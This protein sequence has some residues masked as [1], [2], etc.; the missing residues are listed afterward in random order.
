MHRQ[1]SSILPTFLIDPSSRANHFN[2]SLVSS[3]TLLLPQ[4][5]L[6]DANCNCLAGYWRNRKSL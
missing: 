4:T 6:P 1:M 3:L 2:L 5:M